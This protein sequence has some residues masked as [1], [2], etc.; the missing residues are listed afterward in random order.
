M[1]YQNIEHCTVEPI[2]NHNVIYMVIAYYCWY[3]HLNDGNEEFENV[4]KGAVALNA[5]YDFTQVEIVPDSDLPENAEIFCSNKHEIVILLFN[6]YERRQYQ[7]VKL[8]HQVPI[9]NIKQSD[10]D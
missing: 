9:V 6:N 3:I 10:L 1:T 8:R 2:V 5:N 7:W 4:Y